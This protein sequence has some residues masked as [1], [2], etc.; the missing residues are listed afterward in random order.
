[1]ADRDPSDE[2]YDRWSRPQALSRRGY[3]LAVL[4]PV[5]IAA[6]GFGVVS[7]VSA[8]DDAPSGA[9]VRLPVSGWAGGS[10]DDALLVGVLSVDEDRCVYV[11]SGQDGADPGR[12]VAVWP[13]G[14]HASLDGDRLLLLDGSDREVAQDG[15]VVRLGG[16][17]LP[18]GTFSSE[19][20]VPESG[21]VFAVQSEVSVEE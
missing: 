4:V 14:Y 19:P 9:S 16:G 21:E 8:G 3:V 20:C 6:V 17:Y 2:G 13:A 1:M 10:G 7:L 15:D 5:L 11:E 18:A 12:Y